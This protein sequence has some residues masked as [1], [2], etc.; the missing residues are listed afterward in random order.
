MDK[1]LK[2]GLAVAES[3]EYTDFELLSNLKTNTASFV[4]FKNHQFKNELVKLLVDPQ[5][6]I[7]SWTAFEQEALKLNETFNLRHLKSEYDHAVGSAQ[8]AVKWQDFQ[9]RK[10]LYPNLRYVQIDR[11]TKREAHVP[12]DGITLPVEHRFWDTHFPPNGWGCGCDVM[13]TD[14]PDDPQGVEVDDMP[15]LPPNF[16]N[17]PGKSEQLFTPEH[18]HFEVSKEEKKAVRLQL[19]Q[20]KLNYPDYIPLNDYQV[21]VSAFADKGD[22][23]HN[24][25]I[26]Q[27]LHTQLEKEVK[28]RPHLYG[29]TGLGKKGFSNPEFLID[30]LLGDV[31]NFEGADIS[32]IFKAAKE[33]GVE[34]LVVKVIRDIDL[35]RLK[36]MINGQIQL[37]G[38]SPFKEI[39]IIYK[40]KAQFYEKK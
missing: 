23:N 31:K 28:I 33:Q 32:S 36:E 22:L 12:W 29:K 6:N 38:G 37:R 25:A 35:I 26:G 16:N 7:R 34:S 1:G 13:Q 11:E 2:K 30:G 5:G 20:H 4:A 39:I 10:H 8:M 15:A 40:G 14:A 9:K 3:Y 24:L 19:E 18:P 17:N 27:L 21:Q